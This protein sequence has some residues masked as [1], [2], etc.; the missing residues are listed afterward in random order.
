LSDNQSNAAIAIIHD[1]AMPGTEVE[2]RFD[3]FEDWVLAADA[4]NDALVD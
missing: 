4:N 1:N 3:S 2:E